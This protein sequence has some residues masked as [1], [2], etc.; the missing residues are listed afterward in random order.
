[1]K[2]DKR[3]KR[4]KRITKEKNI[5]KVKK[6]SPIASIRNLMN[7]KMTELGSQ[8]GIQDHGDVDDALIGLKFADGHTHIHYPNTEDTISIASVIMEHKGIKPVHHAEPKLLSAPEKST[9]VSGNMP[10]S[11]VDKDSVLDTGRKILFG[12]HRAWGDEVMFTAGIRDFKLLFPGIRINAEGNHPELWENNPYIDKSIKKNDPGVEYYRV[13][14]KSMAKN[15]YLHYAHMFLLDMIA[16]ADLTNPLPMSLGEYCATYSNGEVGD[17]CLSHPRKTPDAREPFISLSKKYRGFSKEFGKQRGDLHLTEKEKAYNL[18]KEAYGVDKYWVVAPGG[19]RDYTA[20]IWDWRKFQ[21]V[22]NHFE[23]LLKFVVIGKG[24]LLI[25]KLHNVIDLT[26]KF[27]DDRR[28][29][30]SLIYNADGCLSGPSAL[31]HLAAAIPAKTGEYAKPCVAIFGGRE[32]IAWSWYCNHQI[33]HA[34]GVY[35]CCKFGGCWKARTYPLPKSPKHNNSLC[36]QTVTVDGRTIQACMEAITAD[37]VIRAID[38]Y[39]DGDLY[40]Y[41]NAQKKKPH[42]EVIE[43]EKPDY[44]VIDKRIEIASKKEINLLGNLHTDGGGEQSLLKISDVFKDAGWKVNLYSWKGVH[45]RFE[46]HDVSPH[47]FKGDM[48]DHMVCGVPLL[49]Y[50]NDCVWDFPK[51][52]HKIVENSSALVVGINFALGNFKKPAHTSWLSKSGKFKAVVFQNEEKSAEWEQQ[53]I[54]LHDTKRVVLFGA[55]DLDKF[56]EVCTPARKDN[57]E[58]VVIKTC[59]P[60]HRKY[61][62]ESSKSGGDKIHIWQKNFIKEVD[63]KFY[64]RLLK[65]TKN[66]RFEFMEAHKEVAEHFKDEER[67]VFHKW[68][69]MPVTDLLARGH[70]F[71]YRA[72]NMWRDNYPRVMAEALAAGL[73][74]ISE[75][76][77]GTKD[78]IVHGDTGFYACHYDEYLLHLKTLQRKEGLR[79]KMGQYAKDWAKKNLDPRRW[80]DLIEEVLEN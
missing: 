68:N 44:E 52:A 58:L 33:L 8:E 75:P 72:S 63:T 1:M 5:A 43:A 16:A 70:V 49:F 66:I 9:I 42:K 22:I 11:T 10:E 57:S 25:E 7:E 73:P 26:D 67:M 14:Y 41:D 45:K 55:I 2:E 80:V 47:T 18:I 76:R 59:K 54:G 79:S 61:V 24:D 21:D 40:V 37:D 38:K 74:C 50:A 77:D 36:R 78:R 53:V 64:A 51:S 34:N 48:A 32:S 30:L 17:P 71:M 27:N 56:Y 4:Q 29:V 23:G 69:S 3:R 35:S 15:T 39:Y 19:K 12:H 13:G 60:D 20:K 28:G 6:S 62:T 31:M 65:N 46:D